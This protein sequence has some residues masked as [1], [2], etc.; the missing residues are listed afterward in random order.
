MISITTTAAAAWYGW[1]GFAD[2]TCVG[3]VVVHVIGLVDR[4]F[5]HVDTFLSGQVFS[6]GCIYICLIFFLLQIVGNDLFSYIG[7]SCRGFK[8]F[9][10]LHISVY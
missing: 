6:S 10:H 5:Y 7:L 3:H 4:P 8:P 1:C 9:F 2:I